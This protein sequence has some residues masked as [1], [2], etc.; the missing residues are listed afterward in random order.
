M[1]VTGGVLS[2]FMKARGESRNPPRQSGSALVIVLCFLVILSGILIAFFTSVT[3]EEAAV[4]ASAGSL[5]AHN[6]AD[7]VTDIVLSQIRDATDGYAHNPDGSLQTN[8]P[9]CWASQPGMIRTFDTTASPVAAWKLYSSSNPVIHGTVVPENDLPGSGWGARP[10]VYTDLNAPIL[11]ATS[12]DYPIVDPTLTNTLNG[13]PLVDGF[14]IAAS[15][16]L[17]ASSNAAAM[18]VLWIYILKDGTMIAPD[19]G[20]GM[21]AGF[22]NAA[23]QPSSANPIVG[24]IAYWTDDETCKL[25]INTAGEGTPW[26][27]PFFST[28]WDA[29]CGL[30]PPTGK[31]YNRIPGHPATTSLSPVLWS[32][33]GL[34]TPW[35]FCGGLPAIPGGT[36]YD[37]AYG[38]ISPQ[39]PDP[40]VQSCLT[41]ILSVL[42]PR[43]LFGGSQAGTV[44]VL[45]GNP[46]GTLPTAGTNPFYATV[47]EM[48]FPAGYSALL[49][50][51]VQGPVSPAWVPR[52]RFF[53]TTESR[54]PEVNPLNQPKLCMWPE[55]DSAHAMTANPQ[56]APP[57][58][59][60]TLADRTIALCSSLGTN[61][62]F[63]TRYDATSPTND[64]GGRNRILYSYLRRMM[65]QPVPGFLGS[66]TA[67]NKWPGGSSSLQADQICTLLFDY[68]RSCINL[69]DSSS[70]SATNLTQ[71]SYACSYTRPPLVTGNNGVPVMTNGTGQVVPIVITNPDGNVTRGMG[72]FPTINGASLWF[73]A[74]GAN[75]PPLLC[76]SNGRPMIYDSSGTTLLSAPDGSPA[77]WITLVLEF[78]GLTTAKVNPMHPWTCPPASLSV[79]QLMTNITILF[80]QIPVPVFASTTS[81]TPSA[82]NVVPDLTHLFPLY[83]LS[84]GNTPGTPP[85]RTFPALDGN[86]GQYVTL[87]APSV[88]YFNSP[89]FTN[90][91]LNYPIVLATQSTLTTSS[92]FSTRV[93]PGPVQGIVTHP[94]LRFLPVQRA[95]GATAGAFDIPN[96][97]Y[98]DSADNLAVGQ[99]RVEMCYLPELVNVAPGEVGL[100]PFLSM[101][102]TGLSSMTVNGTPLAFPNPA[103]L[104]LTNSPP[105][106]QSNPQSCWLPDLGIQAVL[107]ASSNSLFSTNLLVAS[108]GT[109]AF[110]GAIVSNVIS[111]ASNP[112]QSVT[113]AFPSASFPTPKLPP[114][115]RV[116]SQGNYPPILSVSTGVCGCA[117]SGYTTGDLPFKGALTFNAADPVLGGI[118]TR[119]NLNAADGFQSHIFPTEAAC[120]ESSASDPSW[121]WQSSGLNRITAD[122]VR[123]LLLTG[124]DPRLTACLASVPSGF[125]SPHPFYFLSNPVTVNGWTTYL[126]SA[127]SLRSGGLPLN[128]SLTGSLLCTN[129]AWSAFSGNSTN[130]PP[131]TSAPFATPLYGGISGFTPTSPATL[132]AHCQGRGTGLTFPAEGHSSWPY[133]TAACDF[134]QGA[135]FN[136]WQAGGDFDNGSGFYPDGPFVNKA[137]EGFGSLQ[138]GAGFPH[139]PPFS[140]TLT[141]AGVG[142]ASPSSMVPSPV[143]FGSLPAG[144]LLMSNSAAPNPSILS[145][146]WLTLQFSPNPNALNTG[147]R[148]T[149]SYLAGYNDAGGTVSNP[150][151]PD[152]L[153]LDF[154]GMPVVDPFPMSDAFS[155]SGKVN[156]NCR[157][158]PFSYINRESALRGVLRPLMVTAVEENWGRDY[159]LRNTNG[160]GTAS[161]TSFNDAFS[162]PS[163][164]SYNVMGNAS[165]NF[166]VHYPVHAGQT[167]LQF[168]QRFNAG[169]LFHSPSEICSLWLYPGMQPTPANPSAAITPLV[170]WDAASANIKAWWYAGP[171]SSRK[172][173]TGDNVRERPYAALYPRLTTKSNTYTVHFRVQVLQQVAVRRHLASDWSVWN[174]ASDRI[175]GEERGARTIER[176]IDP[177]DPSLPDFAGL[178]DAL[179]NTLSPD[180]PQ[181]VMDRYYRYRVVSSK[182]FI[183]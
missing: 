150:I 141:P 60:R 16:V 129:T 159:K 12:T 97:L 158:A 146:G 152:H 1:R 84:A 67:S 107:G 56:A 25:N 30:L 72:R 176:S 45:N 113:L 180:D 96:P 41:N 65:D 170:T 29:A 55:P 100:M 52:L 90:V 89:N 151:L 62:Y 79:P 140:P 179:G 76:H 49:R 27:P 50:G 171:G 3:N 61:A 5:S 173:L 15:P 122:T 156:M 132:F 121:A 74:R 166:Y 35:E 43:Y 82:T 139:N 18:P 133:A 103:R 58:S 181:L 95:T 91:S 161:S 144:F 51:S 9:V 160:F 126:R 22:A 120:S 114:F 32:F 77:S 17:Q 109:F 178:T 93:T 125:F 98:A 153:L 108:G 69:S 33:L 73:I 64:F 165:G 75:Q 14:S 167:L 85:T 127:H 168:D 101:G 94:G 81:F 8:A 88:N 110:G 106:G 70:G 40:A 143:L 137:P 78:L 68:I 20:G 123:S 86:S 128:G 6:L 136:T 26:E 112:V 47:D 124:G 54:S 172:G 157:I 162:G 118:H 115:Y 163:G 53:L 177:T 23:T 183:P 71:S 147:G 175:L 48:A 38:A 154:F 148:D 63:F 2:L 37:A 34:D 135:F 142:M 19:S 149:K 131:V 117:D 105:S 182:N 42:S 99:T 11:T 36:T 116:A 104:V 24:R 31:E 102:V 80:F 111:F 10:A 130:Y 87:G 46:A 145:Q 7:S 28:S 174:E 59:N 138:F 134:T 83:N 119:L 4:R 21:T 13:C 164:V 155:S 44:S 57:G 39:Y 66:F 92:G 169:D